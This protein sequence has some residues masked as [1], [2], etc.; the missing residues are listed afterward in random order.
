MLRYL[1]L[2][3]LASLGLLLPFSKAAYIPK[4]RPHKA[5]HREVSA[6]NVSQPTRTAEL[7]LPFGIAAPKPFRPRGNPDTKYTS[8][9]EGTFAVVCTIFSAAAFVAFSVTS[10]QFF[11]IPALV[12]A[13]GAVI[14]GAIGMKRHKRGFA[15]AAM[16]LGF[17]EIIAAFAVAAA[18]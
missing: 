11:I 8:T 16:V 15:I 9:A 5:L 2:T 7:S 13:V 4:T 10:F 14:F 12:F 6:A 17:I 1:L 3:L 18:L